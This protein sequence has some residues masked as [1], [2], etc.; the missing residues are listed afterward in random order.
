MEEEFPE[1]IEQGHFDLSIMIAEVKKEDVP[2]KMVLLWGE[3]R[4]ILETASSKCYQWYP[5]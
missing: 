5:S 2:E 4:K 1:M 3:Q